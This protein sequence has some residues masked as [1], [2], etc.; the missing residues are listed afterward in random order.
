MSAFTKKAILESFLRLAEKKPID[1][2]TVRDIVDDCGV[3]RNTFYYHFQDIYAVLETLCH[4]AVKRLPAQLPLAETLAAFLD[5]ITG[6]AA[7]FPHAA[8]TLS[9][10]LGF[11]GLVRYFAAD[12][13]TLIAERATCEHGKKPAP[14]EIAMLRFAVLGL[15]LD[16]LQNG[17]HPPHAPQQLERALTHLTAA[18]KSDKNQKMP[19]I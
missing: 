13:D 6:F 17:K 4:H 11:E 3:N 8:R 19:N 14:I 9:F 5:V 2:I 18:T 15:C 7:K 1:K 10:S 16:T 12:L